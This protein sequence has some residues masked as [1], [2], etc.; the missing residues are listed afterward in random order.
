MKL[1]VGVMGSAGGEY[2]EAASL[3]LFQPGKAIAERD[4]VI[5]AGGRSATLGEFAIAYDEGR[6]I[7]LLTGSGGIA[8]A[9]A[10]L[11]PLLDQKPTGAAVLYDDDPVRLIERL[12]VYYLAEHSKHP[13]CFCQPT[14]AATS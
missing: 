9:K 14:L 2:S 3:L 4:C 5:I 10:D 8:D 12:V 13:S 6:L 1:T 11:V 7:G